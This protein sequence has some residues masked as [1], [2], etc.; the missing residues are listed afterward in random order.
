MYVRMYVRMYVYNNI[1]YVCMYAC[2]YVCMYTVQG[3]I[4]GG[5]IPHSF[6]W[7]I[8]LRVDNEQFY[9]FQFW[10]ADYY[11]HG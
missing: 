7:K 3:F 2:M 9:V 8:C 1:M 5:K 10:K 11:L 4:R 6:F